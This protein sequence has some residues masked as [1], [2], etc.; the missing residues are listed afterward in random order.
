MKR[1]YGVGLVLAF[2]I[3]CVAPGERAPLKPLGE[4]APPQPY[5]D[6]LGRA[7][8][9]ATAATEAFYVNGWNDL[10]EYAKGLE[11]TAR[12]LPKATDVPEKHKEKLAAEAATLEKEAHALREAAQ[13]QDAKRT[14]DVM[15]R[16]NLRVRELRAEK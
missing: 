12:Y 15:Q 4:N 11:Q 8:V 5:T 13:A 1:A 3:G 7:R 10:E 9:Q 16:V 14:N 6:L 2:L